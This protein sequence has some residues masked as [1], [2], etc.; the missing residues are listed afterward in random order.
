MIYNKNLF[1]HFNLFGGFAEGKG[2]LRITFTKKKMKKS[3]CFSVYTDKI[4]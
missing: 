1:Y 2:E 4:S 3:E